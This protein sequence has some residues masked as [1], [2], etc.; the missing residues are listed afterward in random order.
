MGLWLRSGSS[1]SQ[2]FLAVVAELRLSSRTH[3]ETL[4]QRITKLKRSHLQ[5]IDHYLED[6]RVCEVP[7]KALGRL[8]AL[9]NTHMRYEQTYYNNP[10]KYRASTE[11]ALSCGLANVYSRSSGPIMRSMRHIQPKD[12]GPGI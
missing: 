10:D 12:I 6:M 7:E 1:G 2:F 3:N 4:N 5:L 11:A 9:Q 8:R